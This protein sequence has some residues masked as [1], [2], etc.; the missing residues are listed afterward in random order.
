MT[1]I[2]GANRLTGITARL[3]RGEEPT[4]ADAQYLI[5]TIRNL[6]QRNR[7]Q[8]VRLR[9]ITLGRVVNTAESPEERIE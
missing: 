5:R 3:R 2:R 8:A 4:R 1:D 6:N 9:S 7:Q